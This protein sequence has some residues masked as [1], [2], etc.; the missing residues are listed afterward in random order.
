MITYLPKPNKGTLKLAETVLERIKDLPAE[1]AKA[2]L[3]GHFQQFAC[4]WSIQ[5]KNGFADPEE[6]YN[7]FYKLEDG[8]IVDEC[9]SVIPPCAVAPKQ[10]NLKIQYNDERGLHVV[11]TD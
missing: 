2:L 4:Y 6:V 8:K 1:E 10:L 5:I 11:R 7:T 3:A 9:K